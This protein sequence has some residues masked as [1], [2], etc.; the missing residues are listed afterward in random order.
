MDSQDF[1]IVL[2]QPA[3][4]RDIGRARGSTEDELHAFGFLL[5]KKAIR[6]A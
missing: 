4:L 6:A 3:H 1:A 5:A 2:P